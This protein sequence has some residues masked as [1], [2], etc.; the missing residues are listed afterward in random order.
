MPHNIDYYTHRTM[1]SWEE[2]A[3]RHAQ[4]HSSLATDVTHAAFNN[5]NPDFNALIERFGVTDKSVVQVC[6]NNGIDLLSIKNK[7][8]GRCLGI[9]G[10]ATF[11]RQAI[12][13]SQ[14]AGH[15]DM[16]F[17]HSD[18]YHLP[19]HYQNAFELAVITVGVLNWMP[20]LPRFIAICSSLLASGGYLLLE[21]IHPVLNM[22]QQ[23]QPSHIG[24][25]YFNNEPLR[26]TDG[27]DYFTHEKYEAKEHYFFHH[28]LADILM[29]ALGSQLQLVLA[30]E[31]PYNVGNYCAD[32][33]GS[34]HQPPMGINLVWRKPD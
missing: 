10:S 28:T 2:A 13:L 34:T 26:S 30:K 9:D 14:A 19:N 18:I 27:L 11:I 22:Y 29:A 8:A 5:L 1:A 31:L 16:E 15:A 4:L 3:P 21:E 24:Y 25:S 33:Q 12:S 7:G 32:L 23:A 6:C 20:D 17:C